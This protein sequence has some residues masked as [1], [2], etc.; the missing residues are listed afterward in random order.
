MLP[1]RWRF[2]ESVMVSVAVSKLGI[3]LLKPGVK[4]SGQ[5]CWDILLS[6]HMLDAMKTLLMTTFSKTVDR[7]MHLPVNT[8]QLLQRKTLVLLS[9]KL[10][11]RNS[12]ELN[13]TDY[14][15]EGVIRQHE[16]ELVV[17]R[18]NKWSQRLMEVYQSRNTALECK[19]AILCFCVS[20][21]SAEALVVGEMG[22]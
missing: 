15:I 7:C 4:V 14:E 6:Q 5:Y 13:F 20:P 22:K 10:W 17:T 16:Y 3:V 11:P 2:T 1:P 8:V 9:P 19:G 12:P 18:L 21:D